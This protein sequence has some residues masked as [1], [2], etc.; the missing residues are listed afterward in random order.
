MIF[1][2]FSA[3]FP[4]KPTNLTVISIASRSV[5][6][7]WVTPKNEGSYGLSNVLIELKKD[8][9][10]ILSITTEIVNHYK[11]SDLSPHITYEISVTGGNYKGFENAATAFILT[12]EE[13]IYSNIKIIDVHKNNNNTNLF[14]YFLL[15]LSSGLY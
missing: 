8:N 14:F 6:I 7:S 9:S 10:P 1:L 13:G 11:I 5:E 2:C 15:C 3:I 4:D 12:S